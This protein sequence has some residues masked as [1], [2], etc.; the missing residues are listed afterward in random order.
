ML[1]SFRSGSQCCWIL[2]HQRNGPMEF[3]RRTWCVLKNSSSQRWWIA[4]EAAVLMLHGLPE[5][6]LKTMQFIVNRQRKSCPPWDPTAIY[7]ETDSLSNHIPVLFHP[8]LIFITCCDSGLSSHSFFCRAS[9]A[10][11]LC[12]TGTDLCRSRH[13]L[14]PVC[15]MGSRW[16]PRPPRADSLPQHHGLES[17]TPEHQR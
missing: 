15:E 6:S 9:I 1:M 7:S 8:S 4:A 5:V 11:G 16:L 10:E 14:L 2:H 3:K 17:H 13:H 12:V